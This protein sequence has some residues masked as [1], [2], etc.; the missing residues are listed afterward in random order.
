MRILGFI[1]HTC[2]SF[3]DPIPLKLLYCSLVRSN[4]E[5]C[6]LVWLN[7]TLKQIK[8]LESVQNNFLRFVSFKFNIFRHPQ[9]SYDVVLNFLYLTSLTDRRLLLL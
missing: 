3:S 7:N 9:S 4:L 5:Y 2:S 1:K 6:S 8:M